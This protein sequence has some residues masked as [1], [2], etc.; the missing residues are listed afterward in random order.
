VNPSQA[1]ERQYQRKYRRQ[2]FFFNYFQPLSL[3]SQ[4]RIMPI[5]QNI[6]FS[7]SRANVTSNPGNP[8]K[9]PLKHWQATPATMAGNITGNPAI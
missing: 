1:R 4:A 7:T 8:A 6:S 5:C 9:Q 2:L 3:V